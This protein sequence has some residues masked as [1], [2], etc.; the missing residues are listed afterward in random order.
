[1]EIGRDRDWAAPRIAYASVLLDR[2]EH[3]RAEAVLDEI[4]EPDFVWAHH[5]ALVVRAQ[6]RFALG[7]LDGALSLL[8]RCGHSLAEAGIRSPML[9]PWWLLATTVLAEQGRHAEARAMVEAQTDLLTRWGT[10]EAVGLGALAMGIATRGLDLMVEAVERL[11]AS[12]ARLSRLRAEL[13]VGAALLRSGDDAGARKYLRQAV[14][15]A[16]RC[17]N[18]TLRSAATG[19]LT[20]AGGRLRRPSGEPGPLTA[21]ERRVAEHASA[22][23]TNREISRELFVS[24]R[25]V[26][27]H[28]SKVYRKLGVSSREEIARALR[29][30]GTPERAMVAVPT[31]CPAGTE[32]GGDGRA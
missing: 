1:M 27:T 12:P 30:I 2:G 18:R 17:G 25:T 4:R 15:L 20:A 28:L 16:V 21:A 14:D 7:D 8:Q 10:Q 6:A 5:E 23:A 19:L 24:V 31:S 3:A 13:W 11:A 9:A 29:E 32:R 22:G 26:E